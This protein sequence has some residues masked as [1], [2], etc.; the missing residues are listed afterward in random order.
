MKELTG[1]E[2]KAEIKRTQDIRWL[3][4]II[5][6]KLGVG[7]AISCHGFMWYAYN[8]IFGVQKVSELLKGIRRGDR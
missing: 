3:E 6:K 2:R 4:V 1:A 5:S 8:Q 7:V